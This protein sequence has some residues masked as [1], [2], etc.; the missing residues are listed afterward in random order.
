[1]ADTR[2]REGHYAFSFDRVTAALWDKYEGHEQVESVE[3][4]FQPR[5]HRN[6]LKVVHEQSS[7]HRLLVGAGVGK[8][9]R[10]GRPTALPPT[11]NHVR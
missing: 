5:G 11:V 9:G 10:R 1:M 8:T 2:G 6:A 3:V 7:D 4:V